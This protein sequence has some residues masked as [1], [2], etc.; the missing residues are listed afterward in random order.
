MN[1]AWRDWR[2]SLERLGDGPFGEVSRQWAD[3][4]KGR[5]DGV[6][7]EEQ[8]RSSVLGQGAA[9][10]K[11]VLDGRSEEQSEEQDAL[12]KDVLDRLASL[13]TRLD[14]L[15]TATGNEEPTAAP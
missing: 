9:L 2:G 4:I 12:L 15:S 14:T 11:S 13:E 6:L 8:A 5:L 7:G 3:W 10:L 1:D